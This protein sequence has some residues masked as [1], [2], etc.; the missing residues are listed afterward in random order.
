M[1]FDFTEEQILI[2][3]TAKDFADTELEPGVIERDAKKIWPKEQIEK[4]A[5]IGFLG[6]MV[7]PE[8]NGSGMDAVS[9]C[10]AM[11]EISRVDASAAVVMSVNNSLVCSIIDKYGNEY[12][13]EKY[14]SKLAPGKQIGAFSLSE[15]QS[16]SDASN[17]IT[18]AENKKDFYIINGIKNWVTNGINSD[19]VLVFAMTEK[20]IGHRGISCFILEKSFDTK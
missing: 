17:M 2:K 12:Q 5:D 13:K 20:N 15:P 7:S 10:L 9:Y 19:I 4:M 11:E 6:I 1:K 18:Y 14:L 16:G 8:W 3:K